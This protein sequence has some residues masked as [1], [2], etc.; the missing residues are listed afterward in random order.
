[1]QRT[2]VEEAMPVSKKVKSLKE[3]VKKQIMTTSK[4]YGKRN[5]Y[6]DNTQRELTEQMLTK[7]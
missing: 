6:M 2:E 1:M 5:L 3:T 7:N 4:R